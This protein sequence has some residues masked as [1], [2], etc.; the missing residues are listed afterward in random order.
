MNY[1]SEPKVYLVTRPSVDW[2]QIAAF[3]EDEGVLSVEGIKI[4]EGG[5][6][7]FELGANRCLHR[8]VGGGIVV[9]ARHG[10]LDLFGERA[11]GDVLFG[12]PEDGID[13]APALN[14][15]HELLPQ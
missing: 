15:P 1:V 4:S 6:E 11:S 13:W 14:L 5:K 10:S 2:G 3:L 7:V 9:Q 8:G 12:V